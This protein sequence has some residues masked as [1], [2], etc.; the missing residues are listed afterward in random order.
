MLRCTVSDLPDLAVRWANDFYS[1]HG[2]KYH[3]RGDGVACWKPSESSRI[4]E[5]SFGDFF[6]YYCPLS[7]NP[8]CAKMFDPAG[9]L[10]DAKAAATLTLAVG[11]GLIGG[12][13]LLLLYIICMIRQWSGR[14]GKVWHWYS[15][16]CGL[17]A[18]GGCGECGPAVIPVS[19]ASYTRA[20][21]ISGYGYASSV[22]A[23]PAT[24]LPI[25]IAKPVVAT[26]LG[27]MS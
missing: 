22:P 4:P 27:T 23:A 1:F 18:K 2:A 14:D 21:A 17:C 19:A 5:F 8:I 6:V 12:F 25:A 11:G 3:R 15:H 7:F 13:L 24:T 20:H 10:A 16:V 26:G 9:E